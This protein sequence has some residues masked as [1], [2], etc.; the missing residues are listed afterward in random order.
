MATRLH[1]AVLAQGDTESG[2]TIHYVNEHYD[3]GLIVFQTL[4]PYCPMIRPMM[5]QTGYMHWIMRTF[6]A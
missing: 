5:W 6:H 2:I 1:E 4:A 3:E